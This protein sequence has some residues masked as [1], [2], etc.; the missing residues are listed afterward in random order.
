MTEGYSSSANVSDFPG[1][2]FFTD[3]YEQARGQFLHFA[4]LVGAELYTLPVAERVSDGVSGGEDT[5]GLSTDVAV[6]RRSMERVVVH[7]SG[8]H[9]VEGYAGSAVQA[10]ALHQ[11]SL[12]AKEVLTDISLPTLVFVHVLNPYG[13]KNNRRVNEVSAVAKDLL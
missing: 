1:E 3:T 8:T 4:G 10:A 11:L 7:V 2:C 13:M 9:G 12:Q 6:V 5:S